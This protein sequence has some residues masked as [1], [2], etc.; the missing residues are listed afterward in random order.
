MDRNKK[1]KG[2]KKNVAKSVGH[3]TLVF[4][5]IKIWSGIK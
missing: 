1:S 2:V 3:N 5:L 4:C